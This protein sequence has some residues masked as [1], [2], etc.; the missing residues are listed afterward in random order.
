MDTTPLATYEDGLMVEHEGVLYML[1][2][3]DNGVTEVS[4]ATTGEIITYIGDGWRAEL[5]PICDRHAQIQDICPMGMSLEEVWELGSDL[6]ACSLPVVTKTHRKLHTKGAKMRKGRQDVMAQTRRDD[7]RR[8]RRHVHVA[9]HQLLLGDLREARRQ[10]SLA[11][12][13]IDGKLRQMPVQ[14]Q[15]RNKPAELAG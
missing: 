1:K 12:L 7:H 9:L 5:R 14:P 8:Q 6:L 10:P 15:P 11:L 13:F 3:L 2:Q 4:L